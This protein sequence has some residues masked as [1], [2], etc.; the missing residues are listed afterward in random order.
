[1]LEVNEII[2]EAQQPFCVTDTVYENGI[3]ALEWECYCYSDQCNSQ[4]NDTNLPKQNSELIECK[5]EV[6]TSSGCSNVMPDGVCKGQLCVTGERRIFFDFSQKFL[7]EIQEK[8]FCDRVKR[9]KIFLLV[10]KAYCH[11]ILFA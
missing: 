3:V 4:A 6:C 11:D 7:R 10:Q 5:S 8:K 2:Q 1:M 9:K